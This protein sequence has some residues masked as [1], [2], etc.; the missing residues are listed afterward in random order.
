MTAPIFDHFTYNRG[1]MAA[2]LACN[3]C[4]YLIVMRGAKLERGEVSKQR[5]AIGDHIRE[6]HA[7]LI[8]TATNP[9]GHSEVITG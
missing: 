7:E 1:P 8:H 6:Q 4:K 2:T 3:H 5:K 9:S